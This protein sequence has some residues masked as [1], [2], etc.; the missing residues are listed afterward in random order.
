MGPLQYDGLSHYYYCFSLQILEMLQTHSFLGV[1]SFIEISRCYRY[2]C[3][4]MYRNHL[5][6][7][8]AM[9]NILRSGGIT[10]I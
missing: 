2:I 8:I 4:T 10:E 6:L 9:Y 5:V 7:S 3:T 1:A